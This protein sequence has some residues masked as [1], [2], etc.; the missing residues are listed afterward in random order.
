MPP[1]IHDTLYLPD[2][3][4]ARADFPGGDAA[5]LWRSIEEIM[6]LPD[7]ARLFV[8]HDYRP[9]GREA[10][11]QTTVAQQ[12]AAHPHLRLGAD[13][14]VRMR[15]ERDQTLPLPE[16][17]LHALQVNIAGGRLPEADG[18]GKRFLLIP[19]DALDATTPPEAQHA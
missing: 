4:S 6:S 2:S 8:G 3:G 13:A 15:V 1:F 12:K 19:L 9:D 7:E 10:R 16:L 17:M 11:W 18:Q 14:F 5:A